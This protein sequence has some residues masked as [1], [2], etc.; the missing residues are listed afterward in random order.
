MGI[1]GYFP[2]TDK[3]NKTS[4]TQNKHLFIQQTANY[5]QVKKI[6]FQN[7]GNFYLRTPNK[8]PPLQLSFKFIT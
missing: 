8:E 5:F 7:T 4:K 2:N 3:G 1:L 6:F